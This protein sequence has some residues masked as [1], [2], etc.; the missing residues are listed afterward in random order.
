MPE[1]SNNTS[2]LAIYLRGC[3][4]EYDNTVCMLTLENFVERDKVYDFILLVFNELSKK[5]KIND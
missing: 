1:L 5:W 4:H 2:H 3:D